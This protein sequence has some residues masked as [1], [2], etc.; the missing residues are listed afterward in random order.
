MDHNPACCLQDPM[1]KFRNGRC[2]GD[3]GDDT[4]DQA[5]KGDLPICQAGANPARVDPAGTGTD[6]HS[7][8]AFELDPLVALLQV[9]SIRSTSSSVISSPG[10]VGKLRGRQSARLLSFVSPYSYRDL[11][12]I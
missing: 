10:A 5:Y 3:G 6:D 8:R 12:T 9:K 7:D 2:R 1:Q 11:L 4:H